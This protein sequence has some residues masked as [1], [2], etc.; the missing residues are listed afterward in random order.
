MLLVKELQNSLLNKI[1]IWWSRESMIN[2]D[3]IDFELC[4]VTE[5]FKDFKI[6]LLD[7]DYG[8][9]LQRSFT[10]RFLRRHDYFWWPQS[11]Y[12]YYL[13]RPCHVHEVSRF[14][15]Q[16]LMACIRELEVWGGKGC[17]VWKVREVLNSCFCLH[18]YW[19][20][21][22]CWSKSVLGFECSVLRLCMRTTPPREEKKR[23][24]GKEKKRRF[25]LQCITLVYETNS[26]MKRKEKKRKARKRIAWH[27]LIIALRSR[28]LIRP[29]PHYLFLSFLPEPAQSFPNPQ[30]LKMNLTFPIGLVAIAINKG[31]WTILTDAAL[32]F[33]FFDV[34]G[35]E[36]T[37]AMLGLVVPSF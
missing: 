26:S 25:E 5:S 10:Y 30:P 37:T 13:R 8:W 19:L 4:A 15:K 22:W 36:H 32:S 9:L 2:I 6:R 28:N 17:P 29:L 24:K 35:A 12:L 27:S 34:A 7:I 3:Q 23:E 11:G 33:A 31:W 16:P 18:R 14:S 21:K 20:S 1:K